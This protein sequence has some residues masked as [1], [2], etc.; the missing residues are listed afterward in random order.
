MRT[1]PIGVMDDRIGHARK[2]GPSNDA[3]ASGPCDALD[4]SIADRSDVPILDDQAVKDILETGAFPALDQSIGDG[5]DDKDKTTDTC[6]PD[7]DLTRNFSLSECISQL[8][9]LERETETI[10][11]ETLRITSGIRPNSFVKTWVSW[12]HRV[13]SWFK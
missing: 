12:T 5:W 6:V 13:F 1:D 9:R 11:S 7:G 4:L 3:S 2:L 8:A 10:N